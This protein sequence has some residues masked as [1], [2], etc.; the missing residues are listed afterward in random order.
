MA[1]TAAVGRVGEGKFDATVQAERDDE[2]G[3]LGKRFNEMTGRIRELLQF[4]EDVLHTLTHELN[5]PLSGLK[6]YLDLWQDRGLPQDERKRGEVLQTMTAAVLRME[7]SLGSALRLF[8]GSSAETHRRLVW[9]DDLAREVCT[10]F[11][12]VARSKHVTLELP[13]PEAVECVYADEELLKRVVTNL[14]SNALKYTPDGGRVSIGVGQAN[15]LA[16][17]WVADTGYGI[18][19]EDLPHLFTKFYRASSAVA[20]GQRI[21]GSGL[22]LMIAQR[23]AQELGGRIAVESE[24]G[25]GSRFTVE[26]PRNLPKQEAA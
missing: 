21:P 2:V 16:R 15:G 19:P 20:G 14:V 26:L 22:G 1:L 12:P 17:L 4:R 24:P 7:Q 23:A 13:A 25:K 3:Q 10:L 8:S 18:K 11:A 6:G 5:T 9:L